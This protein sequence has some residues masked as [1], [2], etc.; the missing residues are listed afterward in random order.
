MLLAT[1]LSNLANGGA[2]S[3]ATGGAVD[4]SKCAKDRKDSKTAG[5]AFAIFDNQ[6]CGPIN[7]TGPCTRDDECGSSCCDGKKCRAPDAL[8]GAE[9]CRS[10]LAPDFT[11]GLKFVNKGANG[12][13]G[14]NAG[15][16]A[17][18]GNVGAAAP[19]TG[20]A[21]DTSKCAKDRK[22]SKTAGPA[23]AIFDNQPCG[24]INITGPCTRDDECGSSC[25]DG[26]KCRAPDA[27]KGAETC[28]SGLA[29]DFTNGLKFVNK[30]GNGGAGN[31]AGANAGNGNV[32]AAAPATGGAVD[33]SKCA[34]D[35]KDSKTAGPAF[36][37]FD[38]QPCGP[39]NITGPCTRDDECGSSCC[40]G[41]KCR[42]PDALKGAETCRS[43]LAP[44]F[45]NGLKFVKKGQ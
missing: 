24:P 30:G 43:G 1:P 6:P 44:D 28:R 2:T 33:T 27:L 26:K 5:P 9:T 20:G 21:V 35:R 11:N 42:A 7:I 38:N 40:D 3:G 10:G 13:A 25:C 36:A 32:G 4:T 8:K 19:A 23:F 45:T 29:P 12:G 39:I 41:K 37:I 14:N 22:D 15:A 17:G 31:G 18:N 16:N 34:K